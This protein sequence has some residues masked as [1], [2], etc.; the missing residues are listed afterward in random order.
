MWL[1]RSTDFYSLWC[2]TEL[3]CVQSLPQ[4]WPT[5]ADFLLFNNINGCCEGWGYP[6]FFP[7]YGDLNGHHRERLGSTTT[8]RHDVAAFDCATVSGCDLLVVGPTHA[9]GGLLMTNVPDLV[10]VACSTHRSRY[11]YQSCWNVFLRGRSWKRPATC[12]SASISVFSF[13]MRYNNKKDGAIFGCHI[14]FWVRT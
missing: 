1:L 11:T 2:E 6:R 14:T 5:W 10:R 13:V 12:R 3:S 7:V 9:S 8:N 4:P